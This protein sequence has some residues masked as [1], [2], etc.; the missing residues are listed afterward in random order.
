MPIFFAL[1]LVVDVLLVIH[2]VKT[3]RPYYWIFIIVFLPIAG[4]L[5]YVLV[6]LL[7]DLAHSRTGRRVASDLEA[8][9]NPNRRLRQLTRE[10]ARSDTVENRL[11]LAKE[12]LA[13]ERFQEARDLLEECQQGVHAQDPAL[14]LA[15]AKARFGLA[16]YGGTIDALDR[17]RAA[18]PSFQSTEGHLLYARSLEGQGDSERA[19][20]EFEVLAGYYAGEEARCRYGLL[21]EQAGRRDEAREVFAEVVRSVELADKPYFRA[22]REWYELARE[23]L[24]P[25]A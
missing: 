20:F 21:L 11:Q 18:D 17:L 5:A 19:L 24:G 14:L 4:T 2:I 3:G 6:E 10:A 25:G 7:P 13:K 8:V 15:L 23:R 9:V 12:C 22:Q 16:D 1:S